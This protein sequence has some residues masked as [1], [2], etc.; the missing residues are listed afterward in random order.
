VGDLVESLRRDVFFGPAVRGAKL[1]E[2][3][4]EIVGDRFAEKV[5]PIEVRRGVLTV[6]VPNSVWAHEFTC[7]SA[8]VKSK[9]SK[10]T[11]MRIER[12]KCK[13]NSDGR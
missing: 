11:G 7:C 13:Q 10:L 5:K 2:C 6:L 8:Q 12:I 1:L 3:W 9:I 4:E